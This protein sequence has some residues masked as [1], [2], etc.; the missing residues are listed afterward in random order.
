[1]VRHSRVAFSI[2]VGERTFLKFYT[3]ATCCSRSIDALAVGVG[4]WVRLCAVEGLR[5]GNDTL[6]TVELVAKRTISNLLCSNGCTLYRANRVE[7][8]AIVDGDGAA[9]VC[10]GEAIACACVVGQLAH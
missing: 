8:V 1:M 4:R 9:S 6:V 3:V 7:V 10:Q 2:G 5:P